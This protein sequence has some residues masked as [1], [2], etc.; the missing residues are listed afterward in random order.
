LPKNICLSGLI[1]ALA[2][3]V[4]VGSVVEHLVGAFFDILLR[5]LDQGIQ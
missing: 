4:L 1:K 3:F 5:S 2:L